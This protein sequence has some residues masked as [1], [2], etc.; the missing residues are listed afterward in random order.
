MVTAAQLAAIR[1]HTA[2]LDKA[3]QERVVR[4]VS[5]VGTS[6]PE[7]LRAA[8][9]KGL[10]PIVSHAASLSAQ[11]A[12]AMY[13]GWRKQ[14][15]G[16]RY[17]QAAPYPSF[18]DGAFEA[19]V[20]TAAKAAENGKPDETVEGIL[21]AR[22]GYEIRKSW[23]DT[24]YKNARR[25]SARPLMARVPGPGETC[26]FC[27]MLASR[28]FVYVGGKAG[29]RAHNHANCRCTY[30]PSWERSP[31][32]EGYDPDA[33]YDQWQSRVDEMAK[34]RAEKNGTSEGEERDAVY[35]RYAAA[36]KRAEKKPKKTS[37]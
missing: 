24:M 10:A 14:V 16:E 23:S 28:G 2:A 12:K 5:T 4:I 27:L 18:D 31:Q 19:C 34:E 7:A 36:S 9:M 3:V 26:D 25:D 15:T 11:L 33:M 6:D 20:N 1:S 13:N 22:A 32:V 29:E 8:L 30:V 17:E 21:T 35:A 37:V